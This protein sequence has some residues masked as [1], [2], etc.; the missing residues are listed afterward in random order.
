MP[1]DRPQAPDPYSLL[2]RVG[3]FTLTSEDVE[4]GKPLAEEFTYAG[5]NVSPQLS[6]S[7]FPEGTQGFVV[8]CFDP[9]APTPSGFWHWLL[10]GLDAGTT[11]LPRG[12]GASPPPGTF[13]VRNDFG[14]SDYAGAAPP[15]GDQV[16]RYFFVVHALD[17]P[18]LD[19]DGN[20]SPAVVSFNL[21]FHTLARAILTPTY[22][23]PADS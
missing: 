12:A 1:L 9:D 17:V 3:S 8:T 23:V 7:G 21:A 19:V 6:W 18:R 13:S 10:L 16:H 2:P 4:D 22:Q 11:S 20:A 5:G 15:P 14:T